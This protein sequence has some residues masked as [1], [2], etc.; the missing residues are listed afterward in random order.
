MDYCILGVLQFGKPVPTTGNST[1]LQT[2]CI[3]R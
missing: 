2:A 3:H 1:F